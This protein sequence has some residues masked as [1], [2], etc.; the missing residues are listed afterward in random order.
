MNAIGEVLAQS[1][2][3][4][5]KT[6]N[7]PALAR[8]QSRHAA[9][10]VVLAGVGAIIALGLPALGYRTTGLDISLFFAGFVG[11]GLG[12]SVGYH[13]YFTHGSFKTVKAI[14]AGLAILGSMTMQGPVIFWTALHR[15]HHENS[16][17]PGDPH[18]PFVNEA[19]LKHQSPLRGLWHAYMGWTFIH[20]VPN[21]LRYAPDLLRDP[22]IA[23]I[24]RQYFFWVLAGLALPAIVGGAVSMSWSGALSGFAWGGALRVFAWHNMTWFI[25]CL[26]HVFGTRDYESRDRSTNNGWLALPTLGEAWHNNHHAFPTAALLNF[27]WWQFDFCGL[28]IRT[29]EVLGLAW[30]VKRPTKQA[31]ANKRVCR[32]HV[33][34]VG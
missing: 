29:L 24:N 9:A 33:T 3:R 32:D 34:V 14:R 30:D 11:I 5:R 15:R 17:H 23:R 18:S 13:R 28:V 31:R 27:E 26:T 21:T 20:E 16:D 25:T 12:S 10:V 4:T 2:P 8:A 19:G 6:L 22:M 7:S 1:E